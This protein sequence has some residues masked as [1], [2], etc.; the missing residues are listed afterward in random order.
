MKILIIGS[1]PPRIG[2]ATIILE[3]LLEELSKYKGID[4]DVV[5]TSPR[6]EG[7]IGGID[8]LLRS[9]WQAMIKIKKVDV[10]TAHLNKPAIGVPFYLMA[11]F[12]RKPFVI[13]WF[14]GANYR[15]FGGL[16]RQK[17]VQWLM[18]NAEMTLIETKVLVRMVS[19]DGAKRAAWYS[20]SRP[21]PGKAENT[22]RSKSCRRFIYVGHIRP[23]KGITEMIEA[24]ERLNTACTLDVYGPFYDGLSERIFNNCKNLKYSGL[25]SPKEVI[26]VM[27][28]YDALVMPTKMPTEGYPGAIVEAFAA[29]IPIIA[30]KC[31]A[32]PEIVDDTCGILVEVKDAEAL[33]SAMKALVEDD[34][35]YARLCE[36]SNRKREAFSSKFWTAKFVEYCRQANIR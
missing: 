18:R 25:L 17:T 32:I 14:G 36:G 33:F 10:V 29:G 20:N 15:T 24:A 11:R 31:G 6:F 1:L 16:L 35:L 8:R 7:L 34:T 19:E 2:G 9:L 28:K 13:R 5:N 27:K 30:T 23:Y 26:P 21:M 22:H 3:L 4:F 12:W